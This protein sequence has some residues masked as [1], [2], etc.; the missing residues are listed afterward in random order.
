ME[1]WLR[2]VTE[3]GPAEPPD[4][5][6]LATQRGCQPQG[7]WWPSVLRCPMTQR[8][9]LPWEWRPWPW[10][11]ACGAGKRHWLTSVENDSHTQVGRARPRA[12]FDLPHT[13]WKREGSSDAQRLLFPVALSAST[14]D[15]N[16]NI[17]LLHVERGGRRVEENTCKWWWWRGCTPEC[18]WSWVHSPL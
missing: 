14:R 9:S 17:T 4:C 6:A 15:L 12:T 10:V 8:P 13:H 1:T 3:E 18:R 16:D 5:P 11:P 2:L 7:L